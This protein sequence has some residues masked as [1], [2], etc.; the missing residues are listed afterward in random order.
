M[1][2]PTREQVAQ[3]IHNT[4]CLT[5][6]CTETCDFDYEVADALLP[7]VMPLIREGQA[8]AWDEGRATERQYASQV[9]TYLHW[10]GISSR[11]VDPANPYRQD[12]K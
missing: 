3:A 9:S 12:A 11:P 2:A 4:V 5:P 1:T 7:V 8:E 10:S 6:D